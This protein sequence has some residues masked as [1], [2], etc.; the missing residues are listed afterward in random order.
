[1]NIFTL[2]YSQ[3]YITVTIF[4]FAILRQNKSLLTSYCK[5]KKSDSNV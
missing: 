5:I 2:H 3:L 1:M 4:N